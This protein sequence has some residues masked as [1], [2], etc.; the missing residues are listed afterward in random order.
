MST[1]VRITASGASR[2]E[3]CPASA[4]LP[5]AMTT[6]DAARRGTAIHRFLE[7]CFDGMASRDAL[8]MIAP[9]YRDVC[10]RIDVPALRAEFDVVELEV[11]FRFNPLTGQATLLGHG[12]GRQY[13]APAC[14][15]IFGTADLVGLTYWDGLWVVVDWKSGFGDVEAPEDNLQLAF[16]AVA[17]AVLRHLSEVQVRIGRVLAS[18]KIDWDLHTLRR[19]ELDATHERL[20]RLY[21]RAVEAAAALAREEEPVLHLG[22]WCRYCPA[23]AACPARTSLAR[24]M[25]SD[26][27]DLASRVKALTPAQQGSAWLKV[28]EILAMAESIKDVLKDLARQQPFPVGDT[29]EV[30][31]T[32]YWRRTFDKERAIAMLLERGATP[33]E[34]EQLEPKILVPKVDVMKRRA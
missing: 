14:G 15:D 17:L 5:A 8:L 12:L 9:E 25:A 2:V 32:H 3:Q 7:L 18:G 13:P 11:A 30:R 34:L 33:E 21:L 29:K 19:Y 28:Q 27:V 10:A 1:T 4:S 20:E 22:P 24:S 23:L 31:E 6:T 26:A 16:A